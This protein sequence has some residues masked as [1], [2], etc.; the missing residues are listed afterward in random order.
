MVKHWA[1][2]IIIAFVKLSWY[3]GV[4]RGMKSLLLHSTHGRT[5]S[6]MAGIHRPWEAYM[7]KECNHRPW[8]EYMVKESYHIP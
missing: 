6:G 8:I 3:D 1:L 7:V 2:H 4:E 5:T